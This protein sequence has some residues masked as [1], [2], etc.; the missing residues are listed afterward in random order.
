LFSKLRSNMSLFKS[1]IKSLNI[2]SKYFMLYFQQQ[3]FL[4]LFKLYF[5]YEPTA[6]F[7]A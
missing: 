5:V 1:V 6:E 4:A 3:K 2:I 7:I